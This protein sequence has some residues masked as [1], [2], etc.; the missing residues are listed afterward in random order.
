MSIAAVERSAGVT[1]YD[2]GDTVALGI[3]VRDGDGVLADATAVTCTFT[4]PDGTTATGSVL[5]PSTGSYTVDY[6]PAQAGRYLVRWLA[7]GAIVAALTDTFDVRA[8]ADVPVVSLAEAKRHLNITT[9]AS[10]D[11]LRRFLDVAT[12]LCEKVA[13]R[14]LRRLAFSESHDGGRT[15]IPLRRPPV[16]SVTTVTQ[17]GVAVTDY[18]VREDAGLIAKGTY[19]ALED[20]ESGAGNV[21]VDYVAGSTVPAATAE[22]AVLEALRHLWT[23]QRGSMTGRNPLAGD[24][25]AAGTGWSVPRRVAGLL[26][27]HT[28]PGF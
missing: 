3:E 19:D 4:L 21:V 20:W 28:E 17:D 6:V 23:T 24:D 8:A 5:H 12:D 14:P 22:Q 13:G 15:W 11:E 2:L 18:V 7:T 10:D 16:V 26:T 9:T 27:W 1:T 25:Y